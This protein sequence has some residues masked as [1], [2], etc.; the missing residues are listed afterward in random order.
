[1]GI[2]KKAG[3]LRPTV[4]LK[5]KTWSYLLLQAFFLASSSTDLTNLH[6]T[7]SFHL[8]QLGYGISKQQLKEAIEVKKRRGK[9]PKNSQTCS[10]AFWFPAHF[11]MCKIHL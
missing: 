9:E 5:N 11:T 8:F 6:F 1:M 2:C 7:T 4:S 10:S 3:E